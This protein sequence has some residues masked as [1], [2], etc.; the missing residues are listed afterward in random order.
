MRADAEGF[1]PR[2]AVFL[3]TV[4]RLIPDLGAA[5]WHLAFPAGRATVIGSDVGRQVW[6]NHEGGQVLDYLLSDE[7][8]RGWFSPPPDS[9]PIDLQFMLASVVDRWAASGEPSDGFAVT[10][11]VEILDAIREP[12][13]GHYAI[14]WGTACDAN[15]KKPSIS[16]PDASR[17]LASR[18]DSKGCP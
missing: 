9:A 11:A 14:R 17:S 10:H 6:E 18:T 16:A 3:G 12:N 5:P 8:L 2:L 1:A 15:W 4:E 7:T 13:P